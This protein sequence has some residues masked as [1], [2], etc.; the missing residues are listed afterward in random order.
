MVFTFYHH[1]KG[2]S[3]FFFEKSGWL[4]GEYLGSEP[5]LRYFWPEEEAVFLKFAFKRRSQFLEHPEIGQITFRLKLFGNTQHFIEFWNFCRNFL[6]VCPKDIVST[7]I[8]LQNFVRR[9]LLPPHHPVVLSGLARCVALGMVAQCDMGCWGAK[10]TKR[11]ASNVI[12]L[13]VGCNK[14]LASIYTYTYIFFNGFRMD[15]QKTSMLGWKPQAEKGA[16]WAGSLWE[17]LIWKT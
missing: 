8:S 2:V 1:S 16:L 13:M 3:P 6:G 14:M 12:W 4:P 7:R 17:R 15:T 5:Q 11:K 10:A 9:A